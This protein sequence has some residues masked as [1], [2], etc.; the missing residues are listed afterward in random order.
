MA[1]IDNTRARAQACWQLKTICELLAAYDAARAKPENF[2][3]VLEKIHRHPLRISRRGQWIVRGF[4]FEAT[5][6]EIDLCWGASAVRLI[7]DLAGEKPSTARL[8]ISRLVPASVSISVSTWFRFDA[9]STGLPATLAP[10]P[11]FN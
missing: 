3:G 8:E 11:V 5:G 4:R 1:D 2:L 10:R 7:G 6:Y 9:T